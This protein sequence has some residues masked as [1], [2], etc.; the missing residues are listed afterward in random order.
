M[1]VDSDT[2]TLPGSVT[3]SGGSTDFVINITKTSNSH[4]SGTVSYT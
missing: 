1:D 2:V 4:D 3:V